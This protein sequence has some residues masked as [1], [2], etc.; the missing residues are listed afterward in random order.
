MTRKNIDNQY[1]PAYLNIDYLQ[2]KYFLY[3]HVYTSTEN[4]KKEVEQAN[5]KVIDSIS[6]SYIKTDNQIENEANNKAVLKVWEEEDI[7][8]AIAEIRQLN[9][10]HQLNEST[11]TTKCRGYKKH[12]RTFYERVMKLYKYV[13]I[14]SLLYLLWE[15]RNMNNKAFKTINN[16]VVFWALVDNHPLKQ[17]LNNAFQDKSKLYSSDELHMDVIAPIIKYH[18]HKT[19]S[20]H[21]AVNLLNAFYEVKRTKNKGVNKYQIIGENPYHLKVHGNRIPYE[22][23][24]LLVFFMI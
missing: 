14:D 5:C 15:I 7:Q 12:K 16:A 18:T 9:S 17:S 11:L 8:E 4:I 24:N 6:L 1:V 19:I 13:D 23:N 3:Q 20:K 22:D 21:K 2:E 10:I